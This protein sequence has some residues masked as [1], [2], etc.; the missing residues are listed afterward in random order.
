MAD[1]FYNAKDLNNKIVEDT[2]E[3]KNENELMKN[4]RSQNLF[5]LSYKQ[6]NK[7]TQSATSYKLKS[8]ELADFARQ[9]SSM[10]SS[11]I[12]IARALQIIKNRDIKPKLKNVYEQLHQSIQNGNVLS[13]AMRECKNSFPLLMINMFAAGEASGK[14]DKTAMKMALY[15]EKEH[16][17]N[18]K[19]KSAMA[20]PMILLILT[21]CVVI[22]IFT[23]VLPSFFDLFVDIDLPLITKFVLFISNSITSYWHYIIISLI[24]LTIALLKIIKIPT[25][26]FVIDK[27]KLR[28][29][30]IGRLLKTIYTARFART[31]SSLYTSGISMINAVELSANVIGNRYVTAQFDQV[32]QMIKNGEFISTSIEIIDGFDPKLKTIMYIGEE[33]GKLD[34]MLTSISD[35][36]EYESEMATNRLVTYIEPIMIV[37]MAVII[38]TIILSVILPIIDLYQSIG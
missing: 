24:V 4:L 12:T 27:F 26:A 22:I 9:I 11:G 16:R 6:I 15:Y 28:I 20:Y 33:S 1:F 25:V 38:G 17:L 14:L 35:N 7:K 8:I 34:E 3:A 13:D 30:K 19:I 37:F 5:L 36:L 21:I 29:P 2:I 18:S 31:L 23:F 32:I 10:V